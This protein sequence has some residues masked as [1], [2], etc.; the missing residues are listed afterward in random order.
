MSGETIL[1][2][3]RIVAGRDV[4]EGTLVVRG[5]RIAD[6]SPGPS[7]AVGAIDCA[8]DLV[9]PGMI[10]LHTDNLE[11]HVAPRPGVSWPLA[12]A[13]IAHD[14]QIAAAGITTVCD[15]LTVGDIW[16]NPA[17][18]VALRDLVGAI[19]STL[20]ADALRATHLVHLRAEVSHGNLLEAFEDLAA[21][22]LVR[23]TT[24]MDHTP[25][26]RQF[27]DVDQ[28]RRYYQGKNGVSDAEMEA[29]L[30]R[31]RDAQ[32][33]NAGPNRARVTELAH[34]RGFVVGSHDDACAA[35]VEEAAASG[36][37][38]TEF[39]TTIEAAD[40][41]R[42]RGIAI[43]LGA[44]NVVRGKSH[45]GNVS[46]LDLARADRI[47]IL[48]S[49]YVPAS[50]VHGV[51]RLHRDAGMSLGAAVA[52]ATTTPARLLGLTGRGEIAVGNFADILRVDDRMETPVVRAVWRDGRRVA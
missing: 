8:G 33:R 40:S 42:A 49:D 12:S 51:L 48:S 35:H 25:G 2:N 29:I 13:V 37:R 21:H 3:A 31:H 34:R 1:T 9:L 18:A 17:R 6:V 41:A 11:R 19:E 16:G 47:D 44:P 4:V 43:L 38:F 30:E 20:A 52:T 23:V 27:A 28:Y 36:A 22:N 15:A 24:L 39:P 32:R 46:A 14:A 5:D 45:S 7:G 10:E 26:Q 50:L